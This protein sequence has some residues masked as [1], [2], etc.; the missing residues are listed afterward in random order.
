[1]PIIV[2]YPRSGSNLICKILKGL[3]HIID[4]QITVCYNYNSCKTVPCSCPNTSFITKTHDFDLSHQIRNDIKYI[5]MYR[6]DKIKNIDA[7]LRMLDQ[8]TVYTREELPRNYFQNANNIKS[9]KNM[10]NY[11][12]GLVKKYNGPNVMIIL[13]DEIETDIY[14]QIIR[15]LQYFDINITGKEELIKNYILENYSVEFAKFSEE[16]YNWITDNINNIIK[17]M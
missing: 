9:V 11:Y 8:K 13:T 2:S 10:S 16:Y 5:F 17:N 4:F 6:S 12:D 3:T 14:A 15:I 1:M 7:Y